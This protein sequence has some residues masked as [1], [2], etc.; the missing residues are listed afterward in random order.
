MLRQQR[1]QAVGD[2]R[3]HNLRDHRPDAQELL[4]QFGGLHRGEDVVLLTEMTGEEVD[5]ALGCGGVRR[6]ARVDTPMIR[7]VPVLQVSHTRYVH[8]AIT[9]LACLVLRGFL[10]GEIS[11]LFC[12]IHNDDVVGCRFMFISAFRAMLDICSGRFYLH[13]L[14]V[15]A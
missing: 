11:M 12:T 10:R 7:L 5:E 1:A 13:N 15:A 6:S 8:W 3:P 2:D 9:F 14:S 4:G